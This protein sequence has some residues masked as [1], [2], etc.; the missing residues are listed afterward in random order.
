[1]GQKESAYCLFIHFLWDQSP[2]NDR[3]PLNIYGNYQATQSL[4]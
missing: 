4:L 3:L 2:L 1:M